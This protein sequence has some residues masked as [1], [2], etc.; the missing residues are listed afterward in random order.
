MSAYDVPDTVSSTEDIIVNKTQIL[1]PSQSIP[2][3]GRNN[4]INA[5]TLH[6]KVIND[7]KGK[8]ARGNNREY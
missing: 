4:N 7:L 5:Y 6:W 3:S 2:S 8:R 1:P